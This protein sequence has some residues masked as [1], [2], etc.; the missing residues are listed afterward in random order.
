LFFPSWVNTAACLQFD[1][2]LALNQKVS[3]QVSNLPVVIPNRNRDLPLKE[4]S[5]LG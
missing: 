4:G 3:S 5:I 2:D 1:N